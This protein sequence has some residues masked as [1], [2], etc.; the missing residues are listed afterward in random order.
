MKSFSKDNVLNKDKFNLI[1]RVC[2]DK[3]SNLSF[4]DYSPGYGRYGAFVFVDEETEQYLTDLARQNFGIEDLK[5]TYCQ[6]VKYQIVDKNIPRLVMHKDDPNGFASTHVIDVCI[7][8]TL[9]NWGVEV[10]GNLFLEKEESVLFLFGN[11]DLH[12]RPEFPSL[13]E[14]DYCIKLFI[15]FAKKD[16][17]FFKVNLNPILRKIRVSPMM[18]DK[19]K[20][21]VIQK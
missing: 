15:N 3:I 10:E 14:K 6:V 13:D 1:K 21:S 4:L 19:E 7:E 5:M 2:L 18:F 17:W 11:E 8:T 12:G 16:F 20:R 9:D